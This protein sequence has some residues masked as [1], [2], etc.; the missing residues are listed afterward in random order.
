MAGPIPQ[1]ITQLTDAQLDALM[2][3]GSPR[4]VRNNNPGNVEDG[5]F[6]KGLPGY[7]G[8]DGRFAIF[9]TPENGKNANLRLLQRYGETGRNTVAKVIADWA[10]S[11]ENDT[12]AYVA[13][14]SQQLGVEPD[15]PLNLSD[16][17]VQSALYDAIHG[18]ENGQSAD[19]ISMVDD[20]E[21]NRIAFG[22]AG[23]ED[24]PIDLA[25][26][27][28]ED[29]AALVR[30][31]WVRGPDGTVYALPSD[32]TEGVAKAGDEPQSPG[33]LVRPQS[34]AEDMAKSLP[35]GVVE[36]ITGA[37]GLPGSLAQMVGAGPQLF[38][39]SGE[40]LNEGIRQGLGRDY[41]QPQTVPGEYARTVGEFLPGAF[42]PGGVGTKIA[43]ALVPALTS[44]TAGQ[45][46]RMLN[47]GQEGSMGEGIARMAGGFAGGL[48]VGGVTAIRGGADNVL[49]SAA[50]GVT[51]EQLAMAA[52]LRARSPVPLTNA[53][54]LQQVTGGGTGLGRVQR[55]VEGATSRLAPT[56]AER[57]N[58]VNAAIANVLDQISPSVPGPQVAGQAQEAA[59]GVLNTMRQ[60]VNESA[61]PF[62]GRLPGQTLAPDDLAT[63]QANPSYRLASDQ[64]MGDPELAALVSGGPEDLST[65]NR[66][67]QQLDT[68]EGQARPGVMNPTGNNTLASQREQAASLA[69]QL[70]GDAS[71]DFATA[72]Q[73][74]ATGREAFVE[75]LRRGPIGAIA[76][77]SEVQPN[78]AGQT[79]ALFP[80]QPFEGQAA[81]TTQA[82]RLMNEVDPNV[83]GPLVRQHLARSAAEANQ[84]NV[85]GANAFGGAKFAAQTF[86]NPIQN[87]TIMGAVDTAAPMA[88]RD[89]RDLV[90]ALQAT[91]QR[92][93]GG[94]NTSFNNELIGQMRGGNAANAAAQSITNPMGI[95]GR[96]AGSIDDWTA[97][98]NADALAD[99]LLANSDEFSARLTRAINR[100]R[101]ANRFRTGVAVAAGQED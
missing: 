95:P 88:S 73:T 81:E 84:S 7:A 3:L 56:M 82:L 30:G 52:A 6:A 25:T 65:V 8:S 86:G 44:E 35:T 21:L 49:N 27:E 66:V 4:G 62:Y 90:E 100:P 18:V 29:A 47:G 94:S 99:L 87:E 5:D 93:A 31:M 50:R 70:A 1:D 76:G 71:P 38:G 22:A 41:Y 14:V 11:T 46:A 45:G 55:V 17:A 37:V 19:D 78:L 20:A 61:D 24:D 91:G 48:G 10:P 85:G 12:A 80:S 77:Q 9:D 34:V 97:R 39:P 42:T 59:G 51:P 67:I 60:R 64:L 63:L 101:G 33:V 32:P 53:E 72:R 58:A 36:G 98:R 16:P 75:P 92:E 57:P 15:A 28:R 96:I 26:I 89:L 13:R 68:M 79:Q 43:S 23:T 74:V 40:Q 83:A 69:R 54:A 2:N